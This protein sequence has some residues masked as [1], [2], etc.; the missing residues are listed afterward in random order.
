[1]KYLFILSFM[2]LSIVGFSQCPVTSPTADF[3]VDDGGSPGC[4]AGTYKDETGANI[5]AT[6]LLQSGDPCELIWYGDEYSTA[7]GWCTT[8]NF[9]LGTTDGW[10]ISMVGFSNADFPCSTPI[11][12]DEGGNIGYN[13]LNS[14]GNSN[15]TGSVNVEVDVF[16]NA[17]AGDADD[18]PTCNHVSIIE[19]GDNDA[20]LAQGCEPGGVTWDDGASH[21]L[22]ICWDPAV[23]PSGELTVSVDGTQITSY[24]G[25]ISTLI[26]SSTFNFALSSGSNAMTITNSTLCDWNVVGDVT[27]GID[28]IDF[29]AETGVDNVVL[30][31]TTSQEEGNKEFT[32]ERSSNGKD[33]I[34][35]G[36]IDGNNNSNRI[37]K[38]A[39]TDDSPFNG[40]NYYRI[41]QLDYDGDVEYFDTRVVNFDKY[42]NI[43]IF[44]SGKDINISGVKGENVFVNL[45][46]L[47]GKLVANYN[48]ADTSNQF[49][50]DLKNGLYIV[51]LLSNTINY[52]QKISI[53]ND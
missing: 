44:N 11:G 23:S 19:D 31:W 43:K 15:I 47:N 37:K 18:D 52:S 36:K 6:C 28:L 4:T 12:C 32:I 27:T 21:S 20:S 34:E 5:S 14:A 40:Y 51:Q 22:S 49:K 24:S 35:L 9:T 45:Y 48:I 53:L 10:A 30:N 8:A 16:D 50:H 33:Y 42:K 3:G 26:G 39:Y 1:M 2:L 13:R 41:K 38:Y 25:D 46:D 17:T 29:F 7:C